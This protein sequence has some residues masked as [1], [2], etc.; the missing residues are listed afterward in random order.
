MMVRRI[1]A[2]RDKFY[3]IRTKKGEYT[4]QF[5]NLKW[6]V[7]SPR[8]NTFDQSI[9]NVVGNAIMDAGL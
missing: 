7:I 4:L 2:N 8:P 9:L 1:R 3:I 6:N 5:Y